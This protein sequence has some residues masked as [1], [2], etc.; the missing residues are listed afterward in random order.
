MRSGL[1]RALSYQ[2]GMPFKFTTG[3]LILFDT[4]FGVSVYKRTI[5]RSIG[6]VYKETRLLFFKR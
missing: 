2:E 4:I 1:F 6:A 5:K 3:Y